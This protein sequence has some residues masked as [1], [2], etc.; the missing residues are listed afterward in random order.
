MIVNPNAGKRKGEKD[1]P[2]ISALLTGA[3]FEF[4]HEFTAHRDHAIYHDGKLYQDRLPE[5]HR[6]RAVTAP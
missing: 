2:E 1:W 6:S 5:D 4:I 3:G